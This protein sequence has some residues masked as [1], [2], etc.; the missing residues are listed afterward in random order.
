MYNENFIKLFENSIKENWSSPAL[1]DYRRSTLTYGQLAESMETWRLVWE[2]AGIL[3]GD[4]IAIN[5]KSSATWATVFMAAVS[6]GFVA[7]QLFNGFTPSDTQNLVNHSE[8][9][10]LFTEKRIFDGMDFEAM[11][12]LVGVIDCNTGELL[13]SRCGFDVILASGKSML[14]AKYPGGMKPSDVS[15]VHDDIDAV[16]AIMY[17]SGSTGN[18]KGV[19]LKVRNFSANVFVVPH[20]GFPYRKGETYLSLLPYA[21]IFGLTFDVLLP[22]CTGMHTTVLGIP[23]IP[24]NLR[25]ALMD[26]RPRMLFAVPLIY[27][28]FIE[29]IIGPYL[30]SEEGKAMLADYESHPQYCKMLSD[31]LLSSMGGN[32]EV[33]ATG[34]AATP[35]EL[36]SLLIDKLKVPFIT[37]YGMSECAPLIAIGIL[38]NYAKRSC[39]KYL[40][41]CLELKIDSADQEGI[42]GEVLVKGDCV[43]AG[44]FKNDEATAASY[45]EDGWF[46]TGDMG[47][48]GGDRD[49][50][51][52]GRCKNMLLSSNGQNIYPEEIEVVLNELPYVSESLIVQRDSKLVALVVVNLDAASN[53]QLSAESLESVMKQ[54]IVK[55]NSKIPAYSSV[56]GYELLYEPFKKTPKGSIRRFLYK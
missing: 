3:P 35:F 2:K 52:V 21:H 20:R 51:L 26:V 55:L 54:N 45:T 31:I 53:A 18:P 29:H 25:E 17:T 36:E 10:I 41:E 40:D 4:K 16:C 46:R 8:S 48:V 22:L 23:P 1:S 44:Y 56:S 34:G 19:M 43:F 28:K 24:A 32:M 47:T 39:G 42:A 37:G 15:L 38:G 33:F 11:P 49:L 50:F 27:I 12:A 9:K 13:A 6:N 14:A 7:V 5:A 30:H